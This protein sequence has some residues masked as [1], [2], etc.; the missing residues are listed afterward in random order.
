MWC[1]MQGLALWRD[2]VLLRFYFVPPSGVYMHRPLRDGAVLVPAFGEKGCCAKLL[3]CMCV[4]VA[5]FFSLR[6]QL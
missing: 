4:A 1:G 5:F 6:V 2:G 3:C